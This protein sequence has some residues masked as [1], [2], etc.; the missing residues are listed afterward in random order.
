V[1]HGGGPHGE[2]TAVEEGA[3]VEEHASRV[4]A[5]AAG[6]GAMDLGDAPPPGRGTPPPQPGQGHRGC[7]VRD[8]RRRG[9][10]VRER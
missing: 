1:R 5:A 2:R 6:R 9:C 3:V 8:D 7:G 4:G 10:G